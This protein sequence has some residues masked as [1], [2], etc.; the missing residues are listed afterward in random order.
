MANSRDILLRL[1]RIAMGWENDFSLPKDVDWKKVLSLSQEQ[2]VNAIAVDG[3]EIWMEKESQLLTSPKDKQILLEAIGLLQM[4]EV[5]NLHQL[6]ALMKLSQILSAKEIP[7]MIMKGF[8]CAQYY[9]NPQHRSCGDID[10]YPGD[11]FEECNRAF[12]ESGIVSDPYYYRHSAIF[13]DDVM[14]ENHKV[15]ADL[16]GPKRQTRELEEWLE[17]EGKNSIEERIPAVVQGQRIPSALFPSA[18]FNV[19]FLPWHVSAHFMF[20]KITL[21]HLLDWALFLVKEG[22]RIDVK[23]FREAKSKYTYGYSKMVDILTNLCFRYLEMPTADIPK[24]IVNDATAFDNKVADKVF[25]YMFSGELK[26]R[27]NNIWSSRW[28]NIKRVVN[29]RWKYKDVYNVG[30]IKFLYYKAYGVLFRVGEND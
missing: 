19:L 16:R 8:A 2:G 23:M 9:P 1:V 25:A 7:F 10:I 21:R 3:L 20:E 12:S 6:S 29:E 14:V 24:E 30:F 17:K 18:S 15:L 5:N 27:G 22:K 13:I 26:N 11:R 28:N 4:V